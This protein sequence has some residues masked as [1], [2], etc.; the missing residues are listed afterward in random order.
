LQKYDAYQ[1]AKARF[2]YQLKENP[3]HILNID[4]EHGPVGNGSCGPRPLRKYMVRP[5]AN[6]FSLFIQF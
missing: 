6:A 4:F 2:S 3:Y 1:L 5:E